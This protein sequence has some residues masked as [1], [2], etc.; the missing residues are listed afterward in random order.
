[1]LRSGKP[2]TPDDKDALLAMPLDV[3]GYP[4]GLEATH[5]HCLGQS[6]SLTSKEQF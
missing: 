2:G 5:C 3:F 4:P 1:M 6:T